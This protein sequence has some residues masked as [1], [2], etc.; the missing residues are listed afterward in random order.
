MINHYDHDRLSEKDLQIISPEN[1]GFHY[2]FGYYDLPATDKNGENHLCHRVKFMDRM[3]T[4][5]DVCELGILKDRKFYPFAETTAWNFQQGSMLRWHPT[6]ENTVCYNVRRNG[7]FS[8]VVHNL[9]NGEKTFTDRAC[10][11][12]APNGKFGLSVSFSRIFD[13]RPGYGYAGA[14]DEN[15][16]VNCPD[17]DGVYL[18]DLES[19]KS[20]MLITYAQMLGASG[21]EPED[22]ILIN[23][24]TVAPDSKRYLMLVRNFRKPGKIWNTSLVIGDLEGNVYTPLKRT[25]FSH[26]YWTDERTVLAHCKYG[27]RTGMFA[28]NIDSGSA[29][30]LDAPYFHGPGNRDVHCILSPDRKY[31][32]GD[33]YPLEGKRCLFAYSMDTGMTDIVIRL[34]TVV[35]PTDEIR[36]DLHA[37]FSGDGKYI[38]MDTTQNGRREVGIIPIDVLN[39]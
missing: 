8:T 11:T 9:S 4:A 35:P 21:F 24:I 7:G 22:K 18:T 26:Y 20:K 19:G 38:S 27:E 17:N 16:D 33:G 5:D 29:K 34:S 3:P 15:F 28:I 37:L 10:A 36:C 12:I 25:Y 23:H 2:F 1:D 13:F 14:P 6:K 39:F 30:E 31:I 32:I